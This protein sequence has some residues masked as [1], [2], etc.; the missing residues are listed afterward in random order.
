MREGHELEYEGPAGPAGSHRVMAAAPCLACLAL[1]SRG[2]A[3]PLLAVLARVLATNS[4]PSV[5]ATF[6]C[7]PRVWAELVAAGAVP[8]GVEHARVP[9][10]TVPMA[11]A[12]AACRRGRDPSCVPGAEGLSAA[13]ADAFVRDERA[14]MLAACR[15]ARLIMCNLFSL[16]E[17]H[18]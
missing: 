17:A 10:C 13:E 6:A 16:G 8:A 3:E 11:V 14:G 2:D 18:A 4:D 1:G 15:G 5:R 12:L 9:D 7:R